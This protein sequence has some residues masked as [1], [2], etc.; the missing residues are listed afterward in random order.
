MTASRSSPASRC[1]NDW[2]WPGR[3]ALIPSA[4]WPIP[5][6]APTLRGKP[7]ASGGTGPSRLYACAAAGRAGGGATARDEEDVEA[8]EV[9]DEAPEVPEL[10]D[11][12]SEEEDPG[13]AVGKDSCRGAGSTAVRAG[14]VAV[15]FLLRG[16]FTEAGSAGGLLAGSARRVV[17][18]ALE[19]EV[20]ADALDRAASF[21]L[22]VRGRL[23]VD[24]QCPCSLSPPAQPN[25]AKSD[26]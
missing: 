22:V 10:E 11:E 8:P 3:N 21:F 9:E 19:L 20:R 23:V 1:S 13:D 12:A 17:R 15:T 24:I 14:A 4:R 2:A 26:S 16:F 25:Q 7:S 18:L 6:S 5:S